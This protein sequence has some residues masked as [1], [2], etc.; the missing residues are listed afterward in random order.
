M[1]KFDILRRR[2]EAEIEINN[3]RVEEFQG[4]F[5]TIGAEIMLYHVYSGTFIKATRE[6][7]DSDKHPNLFHVKLS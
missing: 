3:R 6:K 4:R 5:V 2:T 1:S 7:N